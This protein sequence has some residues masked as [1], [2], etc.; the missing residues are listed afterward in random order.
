V[1]FPFVLFLNFKDEF[2]ALPNFSPPDNSRRNPAGAVG[3]ELPHDDFRRA[4]YEYRSSYYDFGMTSETLVPAKMPVP[5]AIGN[6]TSGGRED[7]D[8]AG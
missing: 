3:R 2:S 5:S 7:G 8:N 1:S 4:H 6:K